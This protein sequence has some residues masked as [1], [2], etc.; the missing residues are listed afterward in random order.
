MNL[1]K[2]PDHKLQEITDYMDFILK[3]VSDQ[4]LVQGMQ[5]LASTSKAYDFLKEDEDLYTVNDL[6]ETYK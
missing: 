1:K 6:K 2:L 5:V 3:S 4:E